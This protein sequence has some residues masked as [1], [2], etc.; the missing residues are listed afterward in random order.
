MSQVMRFLAVGVLALL[1]AGCSQSYRTFYQTP[2]DPGVSRS[3]NVVGVDVSVPSSLTVSEALSL[4]PAADIVWREDPIGDRRAQVATIM[5][6]AV[7]R[8]ASGL[9]GRQPVRI[10]ITQRRFHALTFEAE[11]R[12]S[13]AGVHNIDFVAT[14]VDARTGAVLA[15]PEAIQADVPA[16]SGAAAV[17]ARSRGLTQKIVITDHVAKTIAGWLG[18][19]P[20]IRN[21]FTR[22]G[23]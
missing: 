5:R 13:D 16:F 2:I 23:D 8:G 22:L 14:V 3:W 9:N 7:T 18:I 19:G 11:T 4:V 20:D 15:G 21:D 6:D 10:Q 1:L 12:L 17:A